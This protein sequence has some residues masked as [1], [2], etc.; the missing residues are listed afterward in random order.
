MGVHTE[1]LAPAMTNWIAPFH[2]MAKI[3][4]I[5]AYSSVMIKMP[6][7]GAA[8]LGAPHEI[9][10][11]LIPYVG[12]AV[13]LIYVL[14][15][16]LPRARKGHAI[17]ENAV[18]RAVKN[19][20]LTPFHPQWAPVLG[21]SRKGA[22]WKITF[23]DP[24]HPY[25]IEI[26][27]HKH[28]HYRLTFTGPGEIHFTADAEPETLDYDIQDFLDYWVRTPAYGELLRQAA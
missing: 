11:D 28:F 23:G 17:G 6:A 27:S 22:I 10:V 24:R 25:V 5:H 14:L 7:A 2:R 21:D 16:Y 20:V 26:Y 3:R 18:M 15:F 8:Y 9:W 4:P 12:V 1:A 19:P 13:A